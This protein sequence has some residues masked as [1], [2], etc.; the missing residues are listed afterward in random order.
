MACLTACL[1]A[2]AA[3]GKADGTAGY[4]P[5][6]AP[7]PAASKVPEYV[8]GVVPMENFRNMY[9]VFKPIVDHLNARLPNARLVL[10]VQRGLTEHQEHLRARRFG[11]SLSNPYHV[12]FSS[13]YDGY[14]IVGKM[15]DDH[16]FRGIWLVRRDSGI[17]TLG[18]LIGKRI[19]FPPRGTLAAT[20]MTEYDLKQ[21]GMV[22][23]RDVKVS[24]VGSQH[25]SIMQVY[26]K[27]VD[28][29]ATWPLAWIS[30]Q[31]LYPR[32]A[33]ALEVRFPT[34]SLINQGVLAR[35]DMP[36]ELV[37]RV[38]Q[39]MA[40]LHHS[41]EGRAMLAKVPVSRFER[42]GTADYDAVRV[43]LERYQRAFASADG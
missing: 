11:F 4:A 8:F 26:L 20:M 7:P 17:D 32:E 36:A 24:Y 22:L 28:A 15:G 25:A 14:R 42:A 39:L 27:G 38:A 19:C 13:Q 2:L 3:C 9:E 30:F 35:D 33:Q 31:R 37:D 12:W 29:G 34:A 5:M 21:N 43:F 6:L 40:E 23:A 41:Q 1:L 18:D 16:A 10:E